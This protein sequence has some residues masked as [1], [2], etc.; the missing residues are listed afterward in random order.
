MLEGPALAAILQ[1]KILLPEDVGSA[2]YIDMILR[3]FHLVF[4]ITWI[5]LLYFFNVVNVPVMKAL[6]APT[7]GKVVPVLLPVALWYFRWSAV[8]TVLAGWIYW[9]LLLHREPQMP[10][11]HPGEFVGRT[12]GYWF[13]IVMAAWVIFYLLLRVPAGAKGTP[14]TKSG[15]VFAVPVVF[16]AVVM[17]WALVD[18]I[19][20]KGASNRVI[21]IAVGGGYGLFMLLNVW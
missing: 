17:M 7:K 14:L 6:D 15:Y 19:A 5:G 1:A 12:L 2:I 11:G 20:Y 18:L 9:V 8:G 10:D 21:S 4:G 16:L 13:L 3:W